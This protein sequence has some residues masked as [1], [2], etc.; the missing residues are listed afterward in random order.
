MR[1]RIDITQTI[2]QIDFP[3]EVWEWID[4]FG[5]LVAETQKEV[6]FQ[7]KTFLADT[8]FRKILL[9]SIN[10]DLSTLNAIYILLRCELIHQASSFVRMLCDSIITLKYI[11]LDSKSRSELFWSYADIEAYKIATSLLKWES[12]SASPEHVNKLKAF[13]QSISEQ[14]EKAKPK[15]TFVTARDQRKLFS[16]WCNKNMSEQARECGPNF[17]RLYELVYRQMSSYIH[18]TAWSLRRQVSYSRDHYQPNVILNDVATI[19]RT[20]T[21]VWVEWAKFCIEILS[22]RLSGTIRERVTA[23]E[24]LERK[25]FP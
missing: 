23:L 11:S 19:I 1:L 18:G 6:I 3:E 16:N 20:A 5:E 9:C 15:Y 7:E 10:K 25:Q 14:Y 2:G 17:Q 22:W 24:E 21:A 13:Q 8:P 4:L 12:S